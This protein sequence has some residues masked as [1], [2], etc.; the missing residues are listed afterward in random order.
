MKIQSSLRGLYRYKRLPGI[1][2]KRDV[3]IV[4]NLYIRL[5][6]ELDK[7]FVNSVQPDGKLAEVEVKLG[8]QGQD[9]SEI[10]SG[11]NPGDVIAVDL[12][13]DRISIFGG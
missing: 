4:P 13:S 5:D 10:V 11:L 9:S 8:L 3:L 6:R 7:A 2:L 12:S 1:F